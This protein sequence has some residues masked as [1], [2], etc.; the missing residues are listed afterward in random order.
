MSGIL[1][2]KAQTVTTQADSQPW[3][4]VQPY[5]R[6]LFMRGHDQYYTGKQSPNTIQGQQMAANTALDPN[7]LLNQSSAQFG[8]TIS[9]DYLNPESNPNLKGAVQDALGLAGSSFAGQYGGAA[10]NNLSNSG[11][12]EGLARTLGN[13]A[14]NAYS[15]AYGQERQNQLNAAQIAPAFNFA[16]SDVLRSLGAQQEAAPWD[17]LQRYQSIVQSGLS[18]PSQTSQSPYFTNP[19]AGIAGGALAGGAVGGP[20]GAGAGALLGLLGGRR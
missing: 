2:G 6:D 3:T 14:T 16:N 18:F 5:L 4:G 1:G 11:Y 8:K 13:V 20:W 7:S 15:N 19:M 9:G 17:N 10:G 12:Q